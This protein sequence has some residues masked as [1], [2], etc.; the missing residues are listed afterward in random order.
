MTASGSRRSHIINKDNVKGL[1]L[2]YAVALGGGAG[3]EFTNATP[4]AEDGF[5]YIT[6]SWGVLYKIDGTSGDAGRI[7]WR[8]DPEAAAPAAQPRRRAVGQSRHHRR[9]PGAA[10]HRHRQGHRQGGV[11]HHLHRHP[12]RDVHGGAARH[13][14]QDHHRRRQWR[15]GRARLDRGGRC[16]DRQAAVAPVHHPGAGRA[17]QRDLE[18]QQQCLA[19]RRRRG[20][21]D[22][23]LRSRHQP[24]P[25]GHRQSGA[26][27]RSDLPPR[28]QPL[29]QQRDL[30]RSR[31]RQDEL[32]LPVHSGRHVGLRRGRNPH[33][34]RRR[35]RGAAAQAVHPF[36]AQRLPLHDG[37][38]QRPDRA[39]EAVHRGQLD[40]GHRPEDRQ[41]ARLRPRQGHPDLCRRRQL[42]PGRA[43]QEGL[44]VPG[45]RQQL[46]AVLLQPE[47]QASLHSH[48]LELRHRHR[49]PREAHQGKR[50]ERRTE[51]D[52]RARGRAT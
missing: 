51:P 23:D 21:G 31:H 20:V 12:R 33:P 17:R 28:R 10:D 36:R 35:G 29:H 6:D 2:A 24:D 48:A 1:K 13:Q 22:R 43:A 8:M 41:A 27:V 39:G 30:L 42:E 50:L 16:Q 15:P 25:L 7:V 34:D 19:D 44:P 47:D 40:Q 38:V 45:G 18:G 26:D 37:P 3:N 5:L 52:R 32:V 9:R 11:G 46:L 14:G 4:L 49:R